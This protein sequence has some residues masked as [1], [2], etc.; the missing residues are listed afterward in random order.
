M[1]SATHAV[2]KRFSRAT[3]RKKTINQGINAEFL[4]LRE[5]LDGVSKSLKWLSSDIRTS[6]QAWTQIA[7]H[8]ADFASKLSSSLLHDGMVRDHAKEVEETTQKVYRRII[9]QDGPGSSHERITAILDKY[10]VMI[11]A[12]EKDY[13]KL[14]MAYTEVARYDRKVD[15]LNKKKK[16]SSAGPK[17]T[18]NCEKRETARREY[19]GLLKDLTHRMR[20]VLD[21]HE[22]VF[23]CAHHAFWLANHTYEKTVDDATEPIR[24]E[25]SAVYK[26]LEGIDV[27]NAP[28]L[29]PIPRAKMITHKQ[30]DVSPDQTVVRNTSSTVV[31]EHVDHDDEKPHTL[32]L[33][34]D[35]PNDSTSIVEV[36]DSELA[37]AQV[38]VSSTQA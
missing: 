21:K 30:S 29:H 32:K 4:A 20:A 25:S 15:K 38:P 2:K 12:V 13:P 27:S 7:K 18:K 8:Q 6:R 34:H 1:A 24:L 11:D 26:Q 36:N 5:Q 37:H 28:T 31:V 17:L 33:D 9:E 23:Q 22:A 35:D 16:K 14:E 10:E 3:T 19:E